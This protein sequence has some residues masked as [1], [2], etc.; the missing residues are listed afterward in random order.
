MTRPGSTD[1][2]V[3]RTRLA[4]RA[5]L[6]ALMTERGWEALRVRDICER[7]KVGRSTFY[8]HFADKEELL[9]SG[10]DELQA[11]L[12]AAARAAAPR[13]LGF[14]R[15]LIEHVREGF[16]SA[17][18]R[19]LRALTS[20][21]GGQIIRERMTRMVC[22]LLADEV[23]PLAP[24]GPQRDVATRYLAGALVE[25]LLSEPTAPRRL[26]SDELE[27]LYRRLTL[28]VLRELSRR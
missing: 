16:W 21:R 27:S 19:R 9:L 28:P 22:E 3:K 2:R 24:A 1:A 6:L 12:R 11:E 23:A 15:P 10:F 7:A 18:R 14:V 26:G 20:G 17:T 8:T 13:R 4:L 25:L 5:S